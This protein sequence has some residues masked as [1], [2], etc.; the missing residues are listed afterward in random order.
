MVT[1][2]IC[3]LSVTYFFRFKFFV[4]SAFYDRREENSIRVVGATKTRGPERVWCRLWYGNSTSITHSVAITAK[5]KV[6]YVAVCMS[7]PAVFF[8]KSTPPSY[9]SISGHKG[10]LELK[11]QCVLCSVPIT[12]EPD[13]TLQC[14]HCQS[15]ETSTSQPST[16]PQCR[17]GP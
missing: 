4:F 15:A 1:Y 9:I 11:V 17:L 2:Y 14:I 13:C 12:T 10:K 8:F 6:S 16:S 5:V 3:I 7:T